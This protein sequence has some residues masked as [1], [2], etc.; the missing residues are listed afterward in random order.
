M[1][2]VLCFVKIKKNVGGK[3][4]GMCMEFS[5]KCWGEIISTLQIQHYYQ[6]FIYTG[7]AAQE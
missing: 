3:E 2:V 6:S 5:R 1:K 7:C 4:K